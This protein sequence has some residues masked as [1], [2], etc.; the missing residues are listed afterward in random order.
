MAW[1]FIT[2]AA[3]HPPPTTG[4]YAYYSTYGT[5]GPDRPGFPGVGQTYVDPV[6]G[7]TVRRL[8][9]AMGQPPG[10]DIY[11]K[12]GFWNADGT[13][14]FHNDGSSKTIINTTTGAVVRVNVPGNFDGS[15]APDDPDTWYY[16]SGA[17]LRKY[18]VATGT[19]SLVKTFSATL[20]ALGGSVD[21][22]DRTGRYMVLNIGGQAR[23]WDK[24]NDVLYAGPVPGNAGD[25]WVGISPDAKYV[26]AAIDDKRSYAINHTTRTVNTTGV[27]FW[28]LCGGHG[29]LLSATD[30]KTYFVTFEC[31][32]EAAIYAV[33]VSL[34]QTE[35]DAGRAQQ[36]ATNRKLMDTEWADDG[37]IAAAARGM[38]QD[39][40]FISVESND[41]PFTGGVSGWRPYKQEIVMA[42]VLTGELRRLAHHRSRGILGSYFYQPRVSVSWD[43]TRVG[44]ASNFGYAGPDYGDIYAIELASAGSPPP[45]P[46]PTASFTNPAAGATLSGTATVTIA[47][48][49]GSGTGYTYKLAVDGITVYAGA[50]NTISWN[51]SGV[52]NAAHTLTATVTDSSGQSGVAS[53]SV[54]VSNN[55]ATALSLAYHG[56]IRDRVGQGNT[57]LSADGAMDG[58]LTVTLNATGGR[59]I[60]GLRL[61]STGPGTW[62]TDGASEYWALAVAA[63]VDG[64]LINN[65]SSMAVNFTVAN[66]GTFAL[67]ASDYANI[68]FAT[69]ATLTVRATFS[70]GTTA[71]TTVTTPASPPPLSALLSVTYSGKLRDRVGQGNTVLSADGM[72]DGT[73]TVTLNA[74]GERT[75]TG[76]RLDSTGPG[77][78]DTNG[79]SEYWAL[80]VA[81]TVDSALINNSSSMAVNF[82]V[83]NGGTFVVFASDYANIEF[84]TGAA[85]TLT[86]TFS[87]GSTATATTTAGSVALPALAVTYGGKLRDRVGQGNTA[88]S[89]DGALDGTLTVTLNAIGGRTITG[90]RLESSAP[91]TWDTDGASEYW[92]LGVATSLTAPVLNNAPTM[93]VS[94]AVADGGSFILFASD[95][96]DIEFAPGATLTLTARFSDGSTASAVRQ[97]P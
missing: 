63:T 62:D 58:T 23:V 68:E 93:A 15:F 38:F 94:L 64:A 95:Y 41:D 85:L 22:V 11:G 7:S 1:A 4:A 26:V 86:A 65:S 2:D 76:L 55:A 74:T 82:T 14:M 53:R 52:S 75:I 60:T 24:Q 73:L 50:T 36:R 40:A 18:S 57:A 43:G 9:N 89:A 5:F 12:N 16:F 56:K 84:A 31:Y 42:N 6:F 27:M 3:S 13:L 70:D 10:S 51:T 48:T 30:G 90:L 61:D 32:E 83:A 92:V 87:D 34:P 81:A 54:T 66:G 33:D 39:W 77:T 78:W 21:W 46:P 79:A 19:T 20:G 59:T 67:F 49:G 29:D 45:P 91:G 72:M 80:G 69:G 96:A 44:W 88:L 71:T 47:A 25:G 28:S 35:T 17:S 37:H 8:T 97:V